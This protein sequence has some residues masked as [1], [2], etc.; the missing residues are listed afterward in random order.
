MDYIG[1]TLRHCGL[2]KKKQI[3]I[4]KEGIDKLNKVLKNKTPEF[5]NI[6]TEYNMYIKCK[7]YK[8]EV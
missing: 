6:F 2:K 1:Y 8:K 3:D 7:F 4:G 5:Q